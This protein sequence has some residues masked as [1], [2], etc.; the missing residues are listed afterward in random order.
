MYLGLP[1]LDRSTAPRFRDRL[2]L[3][4]DDSTPV[5]G[6][7]APGAMLNHLRRAL[8]ASAGVTQFADL[9]TWWYRT[10]T[11][12]RY[13]LGLSPIPRSAIQLPME[14]LDLKAR[15]V[16]KERSR[17]EIQLDAFLDARDRDPTVTHMHPYF[18]VLTMREWARWHYLH[19][20]HHFRQFGL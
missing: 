3:L 13:M 18:G 5:W 7:F 20:D 8:A 6:S 1:V 14:F 15:R 4:R 19:F 10:V 12:R 9:S 11:K 2:S 17:F 16:E